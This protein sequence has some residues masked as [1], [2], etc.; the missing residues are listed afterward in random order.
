MM[1]L[2]VFG[3]CNNYTKIYLSKLLKI[4]KSTLQRTIE[5]ELYKAIP[6]PKKSIPLEEIL[7]FKE[8][9]NDELMTLRLCLS[10]MYDEIIRSPDQIY[11][12]SIKL[13]QL[14][15]AIDDL[16]KSM[17]SHK[18]MKNKFLASKKIVLRTDFF[19]FNWGNSSR[20]WNI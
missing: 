20:L 2:N 19:R 1:E 12:K 7:N 9:Y 6:I 16:H 15:K 3:V 14:V 18:V 11:T 8:K 10:A 17:D 13:S 4:I 5:F